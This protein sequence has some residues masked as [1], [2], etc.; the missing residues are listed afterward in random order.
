MDWAAALC[1]SLF[2]ILG[3]FWAVSRTEFQDIVLSDRKSESL[4]WSYEIRTR[5]GEISREEPQYSS[6]YDFILGD[7]TYEAV[8]QSR[9]MTED[10]E[11]ASLKIDFTGCGGEV[12]LDGERLYSDFSNPERDE[13]GYL[14]NPEEVENLRPWRSIVFS[15]RKI[16][17]GRCWRFFLI[18]RRKV[19]PVIFRI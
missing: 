7:G 5:N 14:I 3:V 19:N 13:N 1:G 4:G 2:L 15:R 16:I 11:G 8:K 10:L 18:I 17:R 6:E 12:F 9:V